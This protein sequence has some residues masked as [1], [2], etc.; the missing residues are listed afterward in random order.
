MFI[1]K[2]NLCNFYRN[3]SRESIFS[4]IFEL[5]MFSA[6][7]SMSNWCSSAFELI[8]IRE[9]I[10]RIEVKISIIFQILSLI[11]ELYKISKVKIDGLLN[12]NGWTN[13]NL[14]PHKSIGALFNRVKM[15]LL[16]YTIFWRNVRKYSEKTVFSFELRSK[17]AILKS[18][19]FLN[20][21]QDLLVRFV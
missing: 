1:H 12:I 20:N 18:W 6:K 4:V 14:N 7:V 19:I 16:V 8:M 17:L 13:L 5:K 9:L 15:I 3:E 11:E 21:T 2:Q 10:N